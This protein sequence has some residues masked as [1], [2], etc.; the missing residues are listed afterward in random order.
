E[1]AKQTFIVIFQHSPGR[2]PVPSLLL[3]LSQQIYR[4]GPSPRRHANTNAIIPTSSM[5]TSISH[6]LK[7]ASNEIPCF[8]KKATIMQ[9][10][11]NTPSCRGRSAICFACLLVVPRV[12]V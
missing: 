2:N 6:H 3:Q 8:K 9:V 1:K 11:R 10:F 7:K 12:V 5:V 4:H